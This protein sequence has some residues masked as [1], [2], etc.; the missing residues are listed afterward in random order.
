[1]AGNPLQLSPIIQ[2][3][4]TYKIQHH[5]HIKVG[6]TTNMIFGMCNIWVIRRRN[7]IYPYNKKSHLDQL[8]HCQS[9]RIWCHKVNCNLVLL[10]FLYQK[11]TKWHHIWN[12]DSEKFNQEEVLTIKIHYISSQNNPNITHTKNYIWG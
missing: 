3:P 8:F 12:F 2:R 1:M 7:V 10:C 4:F 11:F 9:F 5:K 6:L